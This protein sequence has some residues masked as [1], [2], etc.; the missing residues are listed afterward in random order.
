MNTIEIEEGA[1][2]V[3]RALKINDERADELKELC[4]ESV[5]KFDTVAEVMD[6][7]QS[8]AKN[9]NELAY[10]NFRI[11]VCSRCPMS[12]I[13]REREKDEDIDSKLNK[14][15]KQNRNNNDKTE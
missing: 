3:S 15:Y 1:G 11:G 13:K 9:D 14:F 6:I 2:Q 7:M 4:C 8:I 5:A 10:C 12:M